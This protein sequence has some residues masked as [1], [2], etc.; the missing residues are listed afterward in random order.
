MMDGNPLHRL[1]ILCIWSAAKNGPSTVC[2]A[3]V[4]V[5]FLGIYQLLRFVYCRTENCTGRG[6][7]LAL[8]P[9]NSPRESKQDTSADIHL[10]GAR[11]E[12]NEG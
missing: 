12:L 10:S 2:G 4:Q 3:M 6:Q 11:S 8:I 5:G 1:T 9:L 7:R